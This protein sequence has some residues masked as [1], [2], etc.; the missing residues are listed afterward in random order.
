MEDW[1]MLSTRMRLG[2]FSL[3]AA[4]GL[5]VSGCGGVGAKGPEAS[6]AATPTVDTCSVAGW[7]TEHGVPEELCAQCNAKVAA[8]FQQRGDWCKTHNRPESQCFLCNPKLEATF[9]AEYEAKYG[10]K[11]PRLEG[12]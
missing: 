1:R 12:K 8:E 5:A 4:T 9:A 7:C 2:F 6:K 10:K 11:P 3:L